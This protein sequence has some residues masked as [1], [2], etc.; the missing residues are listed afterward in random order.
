MGHM[1]P[2]IAPILREYEE[3]GWHVRAHVLMLPKGAQQNFSHLI[4][5]L[6]LYLESLQYQIKSIK[7][8]VISDGHE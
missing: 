6:Q 8:H 7:K 1:W 4:R 2:P 3:K 5:L